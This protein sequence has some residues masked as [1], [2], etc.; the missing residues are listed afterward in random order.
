MAEQREIGHG[1]PR[2]D[3]DCPHSGIAALLRDTGTQV[4]RR[5]APWCGGATAGQPGLDRGGHLL[6]HFVVGAADGRSEKDRDVLGTGTGGQHRL[7]RVQHHS[8]CG[9][10]P[11]GVNGPDHA[12]SVIGQQHRDAVGGDNRQSDAGNSSHQGVGVV[13]RPIDLGVARGVDDLDVGAVHLVHPHHV[14]IAQPDRRRQPRPI[15][16]HRCRVVADV[17]AEIEAVERRDRHSAGPRCGDPSDANAHVGRGR[18]SA[19]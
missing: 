3:V 1:A 8:V 18:F 10:N 2:I 14:L 4:Q 6:G 17:I 13:E 11:P 15:G 16:R 5:C 19:A 7:Q 12:G 9:A